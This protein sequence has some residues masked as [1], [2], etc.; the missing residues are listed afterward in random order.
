[1]KAQNATYS[2]LYIYSTVRFLNKYALQ[3]VTW[4]ADS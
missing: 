3:E 1:M 4:T 2:A